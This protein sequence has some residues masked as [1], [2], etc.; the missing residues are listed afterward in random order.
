ML[1]RLRR[2]PFRLC[3]P[4]GIAL[5]LHASV[6]WIL[7]I[8]SGVGAY[9]GQAHARLFV[10][11]FLYYFILGFLLT[12]VPRFTQTP[13]ASTAE[14]VLL[15]VQIVTTLT[16]MALGHELA[17]WTSL[18]S[19][20][21]LLVVFAVRRFLRRGQNPPATFLFVGLGLL[22]GLIGYASIVVFHAV[23]GMSA[24][25]LVAGKTCVY[26]AMVLSLI[27]G[28]GGRLVP[29][30][31]GFDQ[32]VPMQLS[33]STATPP[34]LR[35]IPMPLVL[36]V[37]AFGLSI[38]L[39]VLGLVLISYAVRAS[40][41]TVVAAQF[42]QIH[43]APERRT[44]FTLMIRWSCW[45]IV[46]GSWTMV[47]TAS[48]PIAAKHLLYI[49]GYLLLTLLVGGRVTMSHSGKG[50][51]AEVQRHPY[52]TIGLFLLLAAFT[53]ASAN[54]WPAVY[55]SHLGYA[56]AC[57]FIVIVIWAVSFIPVIY[58]NT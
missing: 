9:P 58:R 24:V 2:D 52:L 32:V 3:F 22:L 27:L 37:A 4:V 12:A 50:S 48:E 15:A 33:V 21:L 31:L 1:D 42:W 46:L 23:P 8:F 19:G 17:V 18:L 54:M 56:A 40:V 6:L 38:A 11:G 36:L 13:I 39:E 44:W 26:D 35:T 25:W 51:S 53:R 5:A 29:G 28:V 7:Y 10:G 49:G 57:L 55:D 16:S 43:R 41:I 45:M 20:W 30:I 14:I 47:A 34:F